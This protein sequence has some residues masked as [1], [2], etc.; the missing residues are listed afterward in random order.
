[1]CHGSNN[2]NGSGTPLFTDTEPLVAGVATA[3]AYKPTTTGTDYWVATYNGDT[4]NSSV[5]S[6]AASEPEKITQGPNNQG[7]NNNQQ[8]KNTK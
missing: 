7:N 2:P 1:M 3:A 5:T 4:A 6:G 8:G